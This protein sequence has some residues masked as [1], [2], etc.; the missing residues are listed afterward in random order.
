MLPSN[1]PSKD[2]RL[3][4]LNTVAIPEGIEDAAVRSTLL[5]E[6][7]LEIGAGLGKFA[8]NA[9][10]IGLMGHGCTQQNVLHCIS[11]LGTVLKAQGHECDP[12][13]AVK[14]VERFYET[15]AQG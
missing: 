15:E 14:A 7:D 5:E 1:R 2:V 4:E 9:W 11:A 10:R 13:Q 8:G 12:D 3:P 6:F